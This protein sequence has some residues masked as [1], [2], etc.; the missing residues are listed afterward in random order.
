MNCLTGQVMPTQHAEVRKT[1]G[2]VASLHLHPLRSGERMRSV[3]HFTVI[4]NKGIQ[5]NDRYFGRVNRAGEPS[6]RQITLI[7]REQISTHADSLGLPEIAPGDVR[8]NV[9]T[10]GASLIGFL[11][12]QVRIGT[13]VIRIYEARTPCS[14][15]DAIAPGLRELMELATRY[16]S[17]KESE[18]SV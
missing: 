1:D 12:K 4:K 18:I 3:D 6:R 9:E 10:E 17:S 14:K 16:Q 7:E 13:A 15:M 5:E 11:G 8:A 2:V